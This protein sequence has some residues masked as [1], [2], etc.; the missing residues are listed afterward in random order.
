MENSFLPIRILRKKE[1]LF[2]TGLSNATLYR[3]INTGEFVPPISLG[4]RAVGFPENEVDAINL[5]RVQGQNIKDVVR[6]LM[7]RRK[8]LGGA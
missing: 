7:E 6:T 4:E 2:R 5:A 3:H 1:V 8:Q